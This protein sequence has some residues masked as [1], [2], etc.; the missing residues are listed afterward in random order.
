VRVVITGA[1][2]QLGRALS[3]A[4]GKC[5]I[6][7][8][9]LPAFEL[10]EP[11]C[12]RLILD[13]APDVVVHAGAY[14]DVDAAEREPERAMAVN[15]EGTAR[16]AEAAKQAGARLLYVSTDYVFDG[17]QTTP[18]REEDRPS[19]VNAYGRSKLAGEQEASR[20]CDHALIIRTAWLYGREGRNF[21]K[22]ILALADER[23]VLRVV[24]DQRGCPTSA[25]DL[26]GAIKVLLGR[27]LHGILHVTNEGSCSWFEFAAEIVRL[28]GK[29]ARIEPVTTG[30]AGRPAPR[31]AYSVLS[32]DQR[33]RLGIVMP[34]WKEALSR[35]LDVAMEVSGTQ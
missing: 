31:P 23:P 29:P 8:L 6:S 28:A 26:A 20:R 16:V 13:A 25:E 17:R 35:Y 1:N 18:Y 22:T 33:R 9:D 2:G 7:L 27:P 32:G 5:E 11:S 21:V 15:A 12:G 3:R 10:T 30:Q 14:T 34:H 19:P 4:L 24:A